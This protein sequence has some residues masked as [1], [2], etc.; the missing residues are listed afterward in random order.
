MSVRPPGG[1]LP[2]LIWQIPNEG[3]NMKAW[4]LYQDRMTNWY[5]RTILGIT[6]YRKNPA[7][8]DILDKK[9][10]V[11]HWNR[12]LD[13]HALETEINKGRNVIIS[14]QGFTQGALDWAATYYPE[15]ELWHHGQRVQ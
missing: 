9:I 4:K 13:R 2:I 1:C 14:W 15:I 12:P 11:K 10:E 8:A 3:L 6:K 5:I 7:D